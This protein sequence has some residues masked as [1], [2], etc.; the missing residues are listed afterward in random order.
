MKL[1]ITDFNLATLED[2]LRVDSLCREL[3]LE[4]YNQRVASGMPE[5]DAT[6]LASSADYFVRDYLVGARQLNILEI[7]GGEVRRFAGNWYIVNT[8][9]PDIDELERHLA[10]VREFFRFLAENSA[11]SYE[12]FAGIDS[13]CASL[14]FYKSR[15]EG[16][17]N[18]QGDGYFEWE[19]GCSLKND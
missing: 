13:N 16:F 1:V 19:R 11:I 7:Q 8:L 18:I 12:T 10:G 3:L 9:E 15:I 17:W 4:F 2:E 6:L 14:E 5:H